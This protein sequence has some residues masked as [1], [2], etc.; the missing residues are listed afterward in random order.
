MGTRPIAGLAVL[1]GCLSG[2]SAG[3]MSIEVALRR[4]DVNP[5]RPAIKVESASARADYLR[6]RA[7]EEGIDPAEMRLR[8]DALL[9]NPFKAS[10]DRALALGGLIFSVYCSDCHGLDAD[11]QGWE[12]LKDRPPK[13]FGSF[14]TRVGVALS[15]GPPA[16]WF[17]RTHDGYGPTVKYLDGKMQ[18]MPAFGDKLTREQIW[19]VL[20]YL[21][22]ACEQ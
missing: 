22:S 3:P 6:M 20:T 11:G 8:D 1:V 10:D 21:A 14:W 5:Y 17:E 12:A 7:D 15:G 19:M 2:C 9:Q 18:A 13:D 16:N 4:Y